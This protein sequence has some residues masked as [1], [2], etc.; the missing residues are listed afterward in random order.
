MHTEQQGRRRRDN[1]RRKFGQINNICYSIL[2]ML[3]T[4]HRRVGLGTLMMNEKTTTFGRR[5]IAHGMN[6]SRAPK[7]PP[8]DLNLVSARGGD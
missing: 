6:D 5:E 7:W 4:G 2:C 1:F 8:F 3:T